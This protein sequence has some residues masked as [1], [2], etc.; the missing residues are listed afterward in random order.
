[1]SRVI[2]DECVGCPPEMGCL[3]SSCPNKSVKR[4]YCDE[5]EQEFEPEDLYVVDG[6]EL[7]HD[8]LLERFTT[9]AKTEDYK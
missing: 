9:V 1:M 4:Y 3:G 8:C 5:C 7:C 2:E 6:E